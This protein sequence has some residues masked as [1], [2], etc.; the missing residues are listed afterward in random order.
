MD[1][2]RIENIIIIILVLL[3]LFLLSVTATDRV[4]Q[5]RSERETLETVTALL[6]DYGIS[7]G[8]DAVLLQETPAACTVVRDFDAERSRMK[9]MIGSG[10]S[11]DM[12]GSI[13]FYHTDRGQA[14]LRGTGEIDMLL[15]GG[16]VPVKGSREKTAAKLFARAGVETDL[17]TVSEAAA[18][19]IDC[20]CLWN[21]IP[22]YNAKL[23][24]DFSGLNL[25]MVS[26]TLVLNRETQRSTEGVMGPISAL[27][28][29]MEIVRSE[30]LICS[31]L[32]AMTPGYLMNVTVSGESTL[33]P[34]WHIR[35]D[36]GEFYL[37][38]LS[39]KTETV[40]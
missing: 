29:F 4:K 23:G 30:G 39:G 2:K 21:G 3:N 24:F 22:V 32:D 19:H 15:T 31:R 9:E 18:D 17:W 37:N 35:T 25:S 12:G 40:S 14:V 10:N 13:L 20:C 26:G 1:R 16:S 27:M 36:T 6:A 33:T 34:V 7:I 11:E 8:E 5:R 38:A 28:R